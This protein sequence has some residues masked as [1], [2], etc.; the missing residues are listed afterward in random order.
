MPCPLIS[1]IVPFPATLAESV[2]LGDLMNVA[3]TLLSEDILTVQAPVPKHDPDQ[4][5]KT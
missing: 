4:P 2:N 3:V 5:E 1:A